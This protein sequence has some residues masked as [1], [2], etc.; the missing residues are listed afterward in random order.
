MAGGQETN[1]RTFVCGIASKTFRIVLHTLPDGD[2]DVSILP[3]IHH[4][5]H[6]MSFRLVDFELVS[7]DI[8]VATPAHPTGRHT[9]VWESFVLQS[10]LGRKM[11]LRRALSEEEEEDRKGTM[12]GRTGCQESSRGGGRWWRWWERLTMEQKICPHSL[13]L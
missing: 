4:L 8:L 11:I 10:E 2:E 13:Q 3:A 12:E 9:S 7:H 1:K 5:I 6:E